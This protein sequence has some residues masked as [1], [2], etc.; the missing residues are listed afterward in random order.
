MP[1]VKSNPNLVMPQDKNRTIR[2]VNNT[3]ITRAYRTNV[4]AP[5]YRGTYGVNFERETETYQDYREKVS[6]RKEEGQE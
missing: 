5:F 1:H 2:K 3:G 4:H 6:H